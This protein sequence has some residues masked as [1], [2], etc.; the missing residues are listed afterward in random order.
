ME[1]RT[2]ED[3]CNVCCRR[4]KGKGKNASTE[5]R[6]TQV[7]PQESRDE[8]EE[9]ES[10][11]TVTNDTANNSEQSTTE[12]ARAA[13][14]QVPMASA[15][16]Q[17][18][19]VGRTPLNTPSHFYATTPLNT[20]VSSALNSNPAQRIPLV[21][22]FVSSPVQQPISVQSPQPC[23][24]PSVTPSAS[25]SGRIR[26]TSSFG[27][28]QRNSPVRRNLNTSSGGALNSQVGASQ[29]S[30][31][32]TMSAQQLQQ[33]VISRMLAPIATESTEAPFLPPNVSTPT[34]NINPPPRA[35]I[36]LPHVHSLLNPQGVNSAGGEV[37]V[38]PFAPTNNMYQQ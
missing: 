1:N 29:N 8:P 35:S 4:K 2:K 7:S 17:S 32:G 21:L 38:W 37:A 22:G 3:V 16:S 34:T 5:S 18:S 19:L 13:D 12:G 27:A 6:E 14:R 11:R 20:A 26:G 30:N 9:G 31:L 33:V 23:A 25:P 28:G 36:L 15:S 10:S 24:S